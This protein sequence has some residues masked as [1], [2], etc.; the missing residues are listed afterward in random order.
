M[1]SAASRW[2]GCCHAILC[3]LNFPM[4][5]AAK[6]AWRHLSPSY[7]Y[8][9][10]IGDSHRAFAPTVRPRRLVR[11]EEGPER[12]GKRGTAGAFWRELSKEDPRF[13]F[14]SYCVLEKR[15]G[16]TSFP[17]WACTL[18]MRALSP[19]GSYHGPP[20]TPSS[21]CARAGGAQHILS[22][23]AVYPPCTVPLLC[24]QVAP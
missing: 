20:F 14:V 11:Q 13:S 19:S 8:S 7:F 1:G 2:W 22:H 17:I 4:R 23:P 21:Y 18:S 12:P 15:T 16:F 24:L 3:S 6:D 5:A 9:V 10:M